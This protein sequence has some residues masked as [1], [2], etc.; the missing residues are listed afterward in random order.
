MIEAHGMKV[1]Q[2]LCKERGFVRTREQR[3]SIIHHYCA[4]TQTFIADA[5]LSR[6]YERRKGWREPE[7]PALDNENLSAHHHRRARTI[8]NY[9]VDTCGYSE[10]PRHADGTAND[11]T[12]VSTPTWQ[13]TGT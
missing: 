13:D 4:E 11:Y 3:S 6:Y 7:E 8:G 10:I 9:D 5:H 12:V 1:I 2:T